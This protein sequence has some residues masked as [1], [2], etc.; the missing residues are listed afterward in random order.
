MARHLMEEQI[1]SL[2]NKFLVISSHNDEAKLLMVIGYIISSIFFTIFLVCGILLYLFISIFL[3]SLLLSSLGFEYFLELFPFYLTNFE[4]SLLYSLGRIIV[5][6][7]VIVSI[8]RS[9]YGIEFSLMPLNIQLSVN[10]IPLHCNNIDATIL[11][12]D[13]GFIR[14]STYLNRECPSVISNWINKTHLS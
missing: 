5:Y 2:D 8:F 10:T 3:V 1:H 7:L 13:N 9:I 11:K 6:S 12:Y 4:Y 14:H